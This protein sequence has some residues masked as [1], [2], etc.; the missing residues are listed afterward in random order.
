LSWDRAPGSGPPAD[1]QTILILAF[2]EHQ[3]YRVITQIAR[4]SERAVSYKIPAA[5]A[6][7]ARLLDRAS[8]L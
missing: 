4:C 6:Q 7:L 2:R 8:M 1:R 5:L 3:P